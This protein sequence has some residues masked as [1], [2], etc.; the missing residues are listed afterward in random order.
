[1]RFFFFSK[2]YYSFKNF[3]KIIVENNNFNLVY[4]YRCT[5]AWID[6]NN[7]CIVNTQGIETSSYYYNNWTNYQLGT[8][9]SCPT[10]SSIRL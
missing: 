8:I 3:D 5:S 4:I 9:V 10:K 7:E 2:D 1:M 6:K